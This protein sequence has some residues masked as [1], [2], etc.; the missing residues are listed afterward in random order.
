MDDKSNAIIWKV[1][2]ESILF[3]KLIHILHYDSH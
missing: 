1:K 3:L 2:Y